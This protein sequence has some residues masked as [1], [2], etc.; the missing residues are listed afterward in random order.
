MFPEAPVCLDKITFS[1]ESPYGLL[2]VGKIRMKPDFVVVPRK[3]LII[4]CNSF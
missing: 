3:L 4:T 1:C 2:F